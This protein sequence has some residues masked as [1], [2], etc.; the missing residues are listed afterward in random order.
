MKLNSLFHVAIVAS[1]AVVTA[2]TENAAP[3]G[4][5][6]DDSLDDG[7]GSTSDELKKKKCKKVWGKFVDAEIID[8]PAGSTT[9]PPAQQWCDR[10]TAVGDIKGSVLFVTTHAYEPDLSVYGGIDTITDG[11]DTLIGNERGAWDPV[12][13]NIASLMTITGGTGKYANKTGL[14]TFNGAS[15]QANGNPGVYTYHGEICDP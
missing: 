5:T 2:C 6:S 7:T 1:I 9:L 10:A 14:I 3:A 8:C 12:K 15:Q 11:P 4:D 13:G